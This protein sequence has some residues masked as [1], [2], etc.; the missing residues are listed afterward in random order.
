MAALLACLL[1]FSCSN[2]DFLDNDGG[3][4][5]GQY[6]EYICFDLSG[7]GSPS[8]RSA[9]GM[10][11]EEHAAG[12][13]VLRN[14]DTPDTLCVRATVSDGIDCS[15]FSGET[16]ATRSI[17]VSS[18]GEY[19]AFR[20]QAHC[21]E[22][23]TLVNTFYMDDEVTYRSEIWST[24]NVYYWPG[25]T[26]TLQ[27]FAWAP[28]EA[29]L[30]APTAPGGTRLAYTVPDE[31]T[32]QKDI[33]VATTDKIP[34]NS[35][36]A[37]SL[38]FRHICTAVKFVTGSQMQAGTIESV[39]LTGVRNTGTYDMATDTWDFSETVGNFSQELNKSMSGKETSGSEVT[40]LEGTFMMLPQ[41][42][43]EGAKVQVVFRSDATGSRIL[44]APV[45]GM[46]WPQ[47]QTVTYK[48]SISPE[49]EFKL[50][51]NPELDA[52]YDI[53]LTT[54]IVSDVPEDKAWTVTAPKLGGE[55]VTIQA[56]DD[57][58]SH[59]KQGYWTDNY[60]EI[61]MGE[62][63]KI[64]G[65][66]RGDATYKNKGSG[67]FPIAVFVPENI[68][69]ASRTIDLS[70]KFTDSEDVVQTLSL[71]QLAPAWYG[72]GSIG[73]ER[74]EGEPAPWGFYWSENF[75]L[76]YDLTGS[77]DTDARESIRQYIDWTKSLYNASTWPIVGWFVRLIFGD[78]IPNLD[79]V[80]M[81]TSEIEG[82]IFDKE[83]A[84][85]ITINLGSLSVSDIAEST[86]DGQ[87]NTRE[88]YNFEGIQLVNEVIERIEN[89]P[90]YT[91]R[92]DGEGVI[93]TNNAAI[94]CMK[95]N[96]WDIIEVQGEELL[97]LSGG[98]EVM[99][100]K[101]YLPAKDEISGMVDEDR[102]LNGDYWT[103]TAVAGSN[104][105]AYKHSAGGATAPES[106]DKKLGVRA[107]RR[108]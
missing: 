61:T 74:I 99:D 108:K 54:L 55:K 103:S 4:N 77:S 23:G 33:V 60:A 67:K 101:W 36:K 68:G 11:K 62:N 31:A 12:R 85:K 13:F 52:H 102:P 58:N 24:D 28:V 92:N 73:C 46:E 59:A 65:S 72:D 82:F 3:R 7:T 30:T 69:N 105:Q 95:L 50:T 93:P 5:I 43:P 81:E 51:E 35:N 63:Y 96:S 19:G 34:G 48:L 26:R 71:T 37:V 79:F 18:L 1:L 22:D 83:I 41:T 86:T 78:D 25:E 42:L 10:D 47:G 70:V 15:S 17:P 64:T 91:V 14:A 100:P 9:A 106:R 20:V 56:Q 53:L 27:F 84:D 107:V 97:S 104:Q 90:G 66:A 39:A 88:I 57:M 44:E 89:I 80:T 87:E 98:S 29:G 49:Y 75:S 21:E 32:E 6:G 8:T 94:A 76:I 16:P 38:S 45:G 2:D 40:A